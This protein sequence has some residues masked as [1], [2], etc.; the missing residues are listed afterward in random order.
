MDAWQVEGAVLPHLPRRPIPPILGKLWHK[1]GN[2]AAAANEPSP[3]LGRKEAPGLRRNEGNW[4]G[5]G[6]DRTKSWDAWSGDT[7]VGA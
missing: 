2:T 6:G 3:A 5:E 1:G 4:P 7:T